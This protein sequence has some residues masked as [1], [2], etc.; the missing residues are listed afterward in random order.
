MVKKSENKFYILF[1]YRM[2]EQYLP[3][4]A[5]SYQI[6]FYLG[7]FLFVS[8]IGLYGFGLDL[9]YFGLLLIWIGWAKPGLYTWFRW[10]LWIFIFLDVFATF[11]MFSEK[12]NGKPPAP[13]KEEDDEDSDDEDEDDSDDEDA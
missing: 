9:S 7:I 4:V 3:S 8:H 1:H 10:I 11:R 2:L 5:S 13:L 12:W 6:F